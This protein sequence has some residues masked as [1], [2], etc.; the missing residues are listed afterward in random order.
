MFR[1]HLS[2]LITQPSISSALLLAPL[3]AEGHAASSVQV[4]VANI[5]ESS[6]DDD[7]GRDYEIN[8]DKCIEK[9]WSF[10]RDIVD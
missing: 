10:W 8:E 7:D 5:Q 4:A 3:L 9:C 6:H 2:L 1:S